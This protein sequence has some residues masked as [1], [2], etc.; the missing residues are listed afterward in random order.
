N[1]LPLKP[2]LSGLEEFDNE[3]K[4]SEPTVKKPIVETSKAKTSADKPKVERKHFGPPLIEDWISDSEEEAESK[5]KIEEETIK[6]IFA[7]IKFVKSKEQVKSPRKITIKQVLVNTARQLSTAQPKSTVNSARPMTNVFNKSNLQ[8]DLQDKG[9]IDSR[10]LRHM[11]RNLSYLIDYKEIDGGHV[12]FGGIENLVDHKVKVI[13]CNNRT[14]FKNREM[15]QFCEM[16][17]TK[18]CDDAE[19]KSSQD[20]GFQPSSDDG[21]K[22]DEDLK[23]ENECKGQEKE[24]NVNSTNNV[25]VASING[26]N[27]VGANTNNELLFDPEMSA[28]E[29]ISTFNFLSDHEDDNEEVDM[30][31]MDIVIESSS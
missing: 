24:D 14:E 4:V 26:V 1:V 5:S 20:D 31:N 13:R 10:C 7:K 12:A 17:G 23:Q 19:T 11:T 3:S 9:V 27:V 22:V 6:P 30:N 15:N 29:D 28:L 25:N 2:N 21:K 16:K 8:Q 18:A